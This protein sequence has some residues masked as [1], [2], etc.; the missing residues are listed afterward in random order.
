[1][2]SGDYL[3]KANATHLESKDS[4]NL[5]LVYLKKHCVM[6]LTVPFARYVVQHQNDIEFPLKVSNSACL[7]CRS[8]SKGRLE[9]SV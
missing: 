7:A 1:L 5:P 6:I 8:T 9:F 3:A 4:T 2:N